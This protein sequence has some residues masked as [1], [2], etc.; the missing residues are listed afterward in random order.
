[1]P[2][3]FITASD[4]ALL[5]RAA[6]AAFLVPRSATPQQPFPTVPYLLALRQGA[7][8]DDLLELAAESNVAGW[9]DPPLCIFHELPRRLGVAERRV[10]GEYERA[11]LLGRILREVGSAVFARLPRPDLFVDAVDA[12]FGEL[13]SNGV[14]AARF[15]TAL[16][17]RS[18]DD[19]FERKRDG[20]L[21]RA[22]GA[23]LD[24]LAK[25]G[26]ADG[27][28]DW[29]YCAGEIAAGRADLATALG[30]RREIRIFGL[31][32]LR[33]GWRTLL[34]ALAQSPALDSVVV[35]SSTAT[36]EIGAHAE[37]LEGPLEG[38]SAIAARL[39]DSSATDRLAHARPTVISAPDVEREHDEIARRVRALIDGGA[40]SHR[41]AVV[42]R[43]ARPHVDF[44]VAALARVGVPAMA[45][46]RV[47]LTSIPAVRA[48]R[49]LFKT[50]ADGWT[51]AGLIEIARQP[52]ID[53][54]IEP[55]VINYIGFRRRVAGLTK[56]ETAL[57]ELEREARAHE[58]R[59]ADGEIEP[60]GRGHSAPPLVMIRATREGLGTFAR[61]ARTLDSARPMS[62]WLS[63][64]SDALVR[65]RFGIRENASWLASGRIDIVRR[66]LAAINGVL[67][68]VRQWRDAL[69]SPEFTN[70]TGAASIV[71][72][73]RFHDELTA[74]LSGD[75]ALWTPAS[76]GVQVLEGP[77]AAYRSFDHVFVAGMQG[78]AFPTLAPKSPIL[79]DTERASLAA[80]GLPIDGRDVWDDRERELFRVLVAGAKQS[81]TLSYA[82]LDEM[83]REIG[84]SSFLEA[85]SDVAECSS[86]EIPTSQVIEGTPL[87]TSVD[88]LAQAVHG[89]TIERLRATSESSRYNGRIESPDLVAILGRRFGDDRLWSPTQL[90]ELAKCPWAYFSKRLLR[91]EHLGDPD[92]DM[93]PATRG[94]VLHMALAQF[95]GA[96]KAHVGG[97][98]FLLD[99]DRSWAEPMLG[100]ALDEALRQSSWKWLG[101]PVLRPAHRAELWRILREY[102]EWEMSQHA[103]MLN[104]SRRNRNA[105]RTIRTGA[106]EHELAFDDMI[107]EKDGVR[108]KYRGSIDRVDVS[109]DERV[110]DERFI[111]AIDYKTTQWSTPGG[112]SKRAWEDGIVLQVPLYAHALRSLRPDEEIARVEYQA[113]K[114]RKQVHSLELYTID[115]KA[116]RLV[117]DEEA[118]EQWED[119]LDH[120]VTHVRR[121]RDGDFPA[122]PPESCTCP[123]WCHGRDICRIPG[124]P[125]SLKP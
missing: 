21:I 64:L 25:L 82:R 30:G 9:F 33:R 107:F 62:E 29:Q 43:K 117:E 61:N 11:V 5:L 70:T 15:R 89:A 83:G 18:T 57:R 37:T 47:A 58:E 10:L 108:I 85:L 2:L 17:Q 20:D 56:W 92:E 106:D 1:M 102:V 8:R 103:E 113:L 26:K 88:A 45:R 105:G 121:A 27:R 77:A 76:R 14:D 124:G 48:I 46:Q 73:E 71:S 50:A 44:A 120:A 22:Y 81:L 3:R 74:F 12:L 40:T 112:G 54:A 49:A 41:I 125:R 96:A 111:A 94:G 93:D 98:V 34:D 97:P 53:C 116:R 84:S 6:G 36:L 95:Y 51:R 60:D 101:H 67:E 119:A 42:S 24:L 91:L 23:Y 123:P 69:E 19:D 110:G 109:V 55:R 32:D 114:Q 75:A 7:L 99:A 86:L 66:D 79:D 38:F 16:E 87:Y 59:I 100:E 4:P 104:P 118:V 65:D 122:R 72:L 115:T 78:G 31:A 28:D 39:F 13:I 63:W 68:I 90:E 35:Y 80:A 52:Y